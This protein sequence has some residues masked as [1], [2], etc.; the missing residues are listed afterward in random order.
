MKILKLAIFDVNQTIFNLQEIKLRF[1]K[2]KI[3]PLFVDFWFC[4]ILKEGFAS[5]K[6]NKFV[7]FYR[8]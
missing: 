1:K 7:N 5:S 4:N 3:N 8:K 6:I 2:K